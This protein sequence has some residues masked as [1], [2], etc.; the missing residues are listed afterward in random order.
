LL[1]LA[2]GF[3]AIRFLFSPEG[4]RYAAII[5]AFLVL[6]GGASFAAV[7]K[8]QHLSAWDG[9]Y[10]AIS[11]VTTV[12]YGD[13][14]PTTDTGRV[15]AIAVMLTGIGFVAIITGAVAERFLATRRE[16]HRLVEEVAQLRE[17]LRARVA[18]DRNRSHGPAGYGLPRGNGWWATARRWL[19]GSGPPRGALMTSPRC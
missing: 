5:T 10:W 18:H 1:R 4:L 14:N 8:D 12:G 11:T 9:F 16:E 7:E 3:V 17:E 6:I 15:I 19:Y 13:I 2:R